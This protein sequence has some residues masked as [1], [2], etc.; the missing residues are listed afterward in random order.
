MGVKQCHSLCVHLCSSQNIFLSSGV[1]FEWSF[2][3]CSLTSC[4]CR[5][6]TLKIDMLCIQIYL[7]AHHRSAYSSLLVSSIHQQ[8]LS[9]RQI[10]CSLDLFSHGYAWKSQEIWVVFFFISSEFFFLNTNH[11]PNN[12]GIIFHFHLLELYIADI[13]SQTWPFPSLWDTEDDSPGVPCYISR[14][15]C[16]CELLQCNQ[17]RKVWCIRAWEREW[18]LCPFPC[19]E[20]SANYILGDL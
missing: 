11:Q 16:S 17:R 3:H 14:V 12:L 20:K 13:L 9:E 5:P 8:D 19:N 6:C 10:S 15:F 2:S 18:L 4:C 1:Q 7:S